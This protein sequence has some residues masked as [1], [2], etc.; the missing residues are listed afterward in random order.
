VAIGSEEACAVD[1]NL[2]ANRPAPDGL[3]PAS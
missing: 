3:W 1:R 2:A